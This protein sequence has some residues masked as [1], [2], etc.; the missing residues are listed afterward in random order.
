MSHK[1]I[2][3]DDSDDFESES[4]EDFS[5]SEEEWKPGKYDAVS[6]EDE[7]DNIANESGDDASDDDE[8]HSKSKK[9]KSK[10]V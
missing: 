3:E 8:G 5:A 9:K 6:E 1:G 4:G 10:A 7:D 2:F